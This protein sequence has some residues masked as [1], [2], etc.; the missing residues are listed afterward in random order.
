MI[1]AKEF[2]RFVLPPTEELG[3]AITNA[4]AYDL[5]TESGKVRLKYLLDKLTTVVVLHVPTTH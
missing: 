4:K 1:K 2:E 3:K 5:A